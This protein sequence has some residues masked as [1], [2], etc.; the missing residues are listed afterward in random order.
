MTGTTLKLCSQIIKNGPKTK[1]KTV[2]VAKGLSP[3]ERFA[4]ALIEYKNA[5]NGIRTALP[6]DKPNG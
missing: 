6:N 3:I 2:D 4:E 5:Y 1:F